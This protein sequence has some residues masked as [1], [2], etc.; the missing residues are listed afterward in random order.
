MREDNKISLD[1]LTSWDNLFLA[2]QKASKGKRKKSEVALFEYHL[3]DNLLL[4]MDKLNSGLWLPGAY[5]SFFIHDPKRRLISAAP[6][7]DRVVHH[8]LC[9]LIEPLLDRGFV[10]DSFA[11]RIGKGNHRAL[12]KAQQYSRRFSYVLS[13]DVRKFFPGIDHEILYQQLLKKIKDKEIMSLIAAILESGRGV[14]LEEADTE[15]FPDDDLLSMMRPRGLPIGNLTSQLWG[16]VFLNPL[17]HY[18]KRTLGC[19]GY[20]RYVDDMLLYSNSKRELWEWKYLVR[21]YLERL[22]L[23][24][25]TGSHPRPVAEGI[26]FLGFYIF[27]EK[28]RLKKRKGIQYQRKL[29][30]IVEVY[31]QGLIGQDRLLDSVLAWN[32]HVAYGNT[33]GLR[34]Q[35]FLTLPNEVVIEA[36]IKFRRIL[37]RRKIQRTGKR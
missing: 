23:H 20:I 16:N 22:R 33:L 29:K 10:V 3:E 11:N 17:D 27:P 15:C 36:R 5:H 32:N 14:L 34:K 30:R 7:S 19:S 31:R 25:H 18:I 24:L 12:E 35:M 28:R 2:W 26:G 4:L 9:N 6:F 8:A 1:A 37:E 21:E 13:L